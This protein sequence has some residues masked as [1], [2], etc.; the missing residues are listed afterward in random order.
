MFALSFEH[1]TIYIYISSDV[2]FCLEFWKLMKYLSMNDNFIIM[3][4]KLVTTLLI[5]VLL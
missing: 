4:V 1:I 5:L 2:G 3:K